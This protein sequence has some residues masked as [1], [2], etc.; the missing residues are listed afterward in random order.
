MAQ[1]GNA[2]SKAYIE[3][4]NK[5]TLLNF[6]AFRFDHQSHNEQTLAAKLIQ[7]LKSAAHGKEDKDHRVAGSALMSLDPYTT[8]PHSDEWAYHVVYGTRNIKKSQLLGTV[9]EL[10]RRM[11]GQVL[12]MA[13]EVTETFLTEIGGLFYWQLRNK[14][15][16]RRKQQFHKAHGNNLAENT[17]P[18]FRTYVSWL[19]RRNCGELLKILRREIPEFDRKASNFYQWDIDLF[20]VYHGIAFCRHAIVHQEGRYEAGALKSMPAGQRKTVQNLVN[21]SLLLERD[22]VLPDHEH[23]KE[24]LGFLAALTYILYR[25]MSDVCGMKI[26]QTP[27]GCPD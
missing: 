4:V 20:S 27:R 10:N 19:C 22:V 7:R 2:F 14:L 16:V 23:V 5:L 21:R 8:E 26:D 15:A 12:C 6:L 18:Y 24:C 13:F 3:G 9:Q 25:E 1:K 11:Q 17:L